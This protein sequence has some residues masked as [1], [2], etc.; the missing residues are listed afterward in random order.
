MQGAVGLRMRGAIGQQRD[1]GCQSSHEEIVS[2]DER[3]LRGSQQASD[4][5][6][7]CVGSAGATEFLKIIVKKRVK[8]ACVPPHHRLMQLDLKC[9]KLAEKRRL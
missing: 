7:L 8:T 9:F 4:D 6:G 1:V 2:H 5:V 3:V